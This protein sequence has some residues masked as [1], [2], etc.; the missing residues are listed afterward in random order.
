MPP[1]A[2]GPPGLPTWGPPGATQS[3]QQPKKGHLAFA[4]FHVGNPGHLWRGELGSMLGE[5]VLASGIVMWLAYLTYSPRVVAS[6]LIAMALPALLSGPLGATLT[7]VEEPAGLFK[8]VGRLRFVFALLLIAMHYLTILPVLYLLLFAVSL[9]GRLRAKLR[10]AAMR[11][12][13]APNEPERVAASTHFAAVI[14]AV[15]G[16]L[17]GTLLFILNGE[18]IL[19][20]A[21]GSAVIFLIGTSSDALLEALPRQHRAFLL[22]KPPP[23]TRDL[24]DDDEYED[25]A[26]ATADAAYDDDA[27]DDDPKQAAERREA[28]LPE[29]QQWGPG[30][31]G[32]ALAD[33]SAGLRLAGGSGTSTAA[34]RA[35][36]ALSVIGGGIGVFEVFYVTDRL[37]L[38]TFYFGALL[39]AQG[40]G[41]AIGATLWSDLG[42]KGA[43][44][45]ATFIGTILTGIALM[46][47]AAVTRLPLAIAFGLLMGGANALAVEGARE[48]LRSGF[49]GVERRALAAAEA[50]VVALCGIAGAAIY[51]LLHHGYTLVQR[52]SHR[53]VLQPLTAVQMF[54]L[55]GLAL[56]IAGILLIALIQVGAALDRSRER[57]EAVADAKGSSFSRG[58]ALP[59]GDG[60]DDLDASGSYPAAGAWDDAEPDDEWDETPD[61]YADSRYTSSYDD[62]RYAPR[63]DA[64][65]RGGRRSQSDWDE[66]EDEDGDW[67]R[68]SRGGRGGRGGWR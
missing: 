22:A 30:T 43:G 36:A 54:W 20:V 26:A 31:I 29:W 55:S 21:V 32:Q 53:V 14:V 35:L 8:L 67:Q 11:A 56:I 39:A 1:G 3:Q 46:G 5:A 9:C 52:T 68:G 24:V 13:L 62:S 65:R 10:I 63:V 18:R 41:M 23:K 64:G 47:M 42:R 28:A 4:I 51:V 38:A 2:Y 61:E 57:R 45:A 66:D 12:C 16:P 60:E 25:E 27:E 59:V 50:A 48:A 34:L 40:A 44:R 49:D 58:R 7:R 33:I 19:L 6:A 15:V 17:L 37:F